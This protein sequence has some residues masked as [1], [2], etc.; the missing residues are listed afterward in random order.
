MLE[1]PRL[2]YSREQSVSI[3]LII[4]LELSYLDLC[5]LPLART[6]LLK[7]NVTYCYESDLLPLLDYVAFLL[8]LD[9]TY[10]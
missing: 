1:H 8:L 3:A 10:Y 2:E 7:L 4:N 6:E 9:W 5:I